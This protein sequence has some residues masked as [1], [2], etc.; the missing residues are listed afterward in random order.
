MDVRKLLFRL[1]HEGRTIIF[2]SHLLQ[3]VEALCDRVGILVR[4]RMTRIGRLSE[5][6]GECSMPWPDFIAEPNV[7]KI[8]DLFSDREPRESGC[9]A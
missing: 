5:I 1:K 4:G 3:D 9:T 7:G 2:S 6:L 8:D